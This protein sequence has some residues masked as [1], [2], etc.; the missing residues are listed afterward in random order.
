MTPC[1]WGPLII[2]PLLKLATP[3][4]TRRSPAMSILPSSSRSFSA[5]RTL[6]AHALCLTQPLEVPTN[7]RFWACRVA[8]EK[9]E[10][11]SRDQ[12]K[13]AKGQEHLS[14]FL[15]HPPTQ[16]KN[17]RKRRKMRYFGFAPSGSCCTWT[18]VAQHVYHIV[19][20]ATGS[21]F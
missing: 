15:P 8:G 9:V 12:G 10:G 7:A 1:P 17:Q 13:Q 20:H 11:Y 5:M 18:A 2:C 14:Q 16:K 21:Y 6:C 19:K 4:G 3:G